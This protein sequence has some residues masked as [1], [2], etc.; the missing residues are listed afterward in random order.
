MKRLIAVLVIVGAGMLAGYALGG[1]QIDYVDKSRLDPERVFDHLPKAHKAVALVM[2]DEI[3]IIRQWDTSF[4]AA[5][6]ASTSL[7]DLKTRVAAL[8]AMPDRTPAQ[9]KSAVTAKFRSL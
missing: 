7:A 2:L 4:K 1:V 3:N 9:L 8:P 6:A 5:V